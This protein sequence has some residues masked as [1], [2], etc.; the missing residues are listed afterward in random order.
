MTYRALA[1]NPGSTSTKIAVFD[2]E[3]EVFTKTLRHDPV[4]LEKFG[5]I[6]EQYEFRKELVLEAMK[7][8]NVT[9]ESLDACVGRGGLV[10]AVEGGTYPVSEKMLADLSDPTKWGRI[11][12]SNLGA[13]IASSIAD[14]MGK[15]SFIVDP[16]TVD[17]FDEIARVSGI[18]EIQRQSLFHALNIRY[19]ARLLAKQLNID[20]HTM[21]MIAVHMGGGISVCAVEQGRVTDTNNALLGMGPFSPQRAGALPIGDLLDMAFS[22]KW[23]KKELQKYLSKKAGLMAYL[24]TDDGVMIE[25]EIDKVKAGQDGDEKVKFYHDAMCYQVAKEMGAMATALCGKV[26]AI[27]LTGG[28]VYNPHLREELKRR[29]E[30]IAPLYFF[31]GEKEMEA[32][33]QGAIRVLKGEEEAKVY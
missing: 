29:T 24:V 32:L 20:F 11:H 12:A 28:L 19:T 2:D 13:F 15:P 17:E 30:S 10:R 21:N 25:K 22:G 4:E 26:D 23:S 1:I 7:E 18:P 5:G 33:T 9:P 31:P 3:Q 16:V 14:D 27:F 6:I 8:N